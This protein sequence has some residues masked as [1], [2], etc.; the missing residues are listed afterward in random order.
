MLQK[1]K[2]VGTVLGRRI[3]WA[4]DAFEPNLDAHQDTAKYIHQIVDQAGGTV[5]PVYVLNAAQLNL[6]EEVSGPW[7]EHYQPAAEKALTKMIS[8][9]GASLPIEKPHILLQ[10][11]PSTYEATDLLASFAQSMNASAIVVNSHG[12]SGMTRFFLGSFTE[13]LLTKSTIPVLVLGPKLIDRSRPRAVSQILFPTEFGSHSQDIFRRVVQLAIELKSQLTLFHAVP[14]PIEPLFQSGVYLLGG[15]W[16]PIQNYF[17]EEVDRQK[18]HAEAWTRWAEHQGVKTH[19]V[20]NTDGG[21]I[22]QL[23]VDLARTENTSLIAMEEQSGP[24][25]AALLG[26]VTRQVIRSAPCPVWV[27][28]HVKPSPGTLLHPQQKAA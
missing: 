7:I 12:R 6:T 10:R 19:F 9:I 16:I 13:T 21:G 5:V 26:S 20:L 2:M 11:S 18:R 3:I 22:S 15:S 27:M 4:I 24:I 23:L 28:R 14:H 8:L 25:A 1:S 17:G